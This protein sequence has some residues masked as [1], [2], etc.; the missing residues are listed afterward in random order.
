MANPGSLPV[1][2]AFSR[3]EL[4]R[5][6]RLRETNV[7]VGTSVVEIL[8]GNPNRL[9]WMLTNNGAAAV[10]WS[11]RRDGLA[12][13]AG[14]NLAGGDGNASMTVRDDW[15]ATTY[16]V[17]GVSSAAGNNVHVW[18]LLGDQETLEDRAGA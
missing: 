10:K 16:P 1:A 3:R 5:Q 4:G 12:T 6:T 13:T 11:S 9:A 2:A 8:G 18:E 17:F 15:E 14:N 7:D